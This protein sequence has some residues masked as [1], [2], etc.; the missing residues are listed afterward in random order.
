MKYC[1][2]FLVSGGKGL[3]AE[4]GLKRA[5]AATLM[6]LALPGSTYLYQ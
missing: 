3:E 1:N 4:L 5:R 2:E 6:M